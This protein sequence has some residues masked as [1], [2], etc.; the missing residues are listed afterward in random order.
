MSAEGATK[1]EGST[2][3]MVATAALA[4][5]QV[6]QTP[7]S[8][9]AVYNGL[10]AA[11]IGDYVALCTCGVRPVLKT[12][13]IAFLPGQEVWWKVS[14]NRA[15]YRMAGDFYVGIAT[16]G[17]AA[18]A[19]TVDVAMNALPN[20]V[21]DTAQ[22]TGEWVS[23][24]TNGLGVVE[25]VGGLLTLAFDAVSEAAQAAFYGVRSVNVAERPIFEIEM[26][27]YGIG[28][29]AN[30]FSI[31]LADGSHATDFDQVSDYAVFHLDAADLTLKTATDDT[32][33]PV[34]PDDSGVDL[35]DDTFAFLQIDARDADNVKF[36]A[37]GVQ[38]NSAATFVLTAS[39]ADLVPI[40]HIEKTSDAA[41]ADVRVRRM[42]LRSCVAA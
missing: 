24:A 1:H 12:A 39:T 14:T 27:V 26:A 32:A 37:N 42:T 16:V 35:V 19:T 29:A 4:S 40:V 21:S 13:D 2:V 38:L 36:Y 23:E 30:D 17:A 31:G 25:S 28:A 34:S 5:G 20:Y 15:T 7:D 10:K 33:N 11:A 22:R 8:R 41:V 18:S 6:I 3:K 9:A